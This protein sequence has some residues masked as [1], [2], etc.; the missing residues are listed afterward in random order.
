M[1]DTNSLNL[2]NQDTDGARPRDASHMPA[3]DASGHTLFE[4]IGVGGMGEVYRYG[5]DALQRDLAIKVI[6]PEM[7]GDHDAEERFLREA[8]LTGAL[9]HPGIVPVHNLGRLADGR[10]FYTM[11]LVRGRTLA[12]LLRD[13]SDGPERLPRLLAVVEK[14]CQAVAY[15]HS[16]GVIHRDLKPSCEPTALR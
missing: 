15:A 4:R 10:L 7:H 1:P 6:K 5:D 14:V 9:Q 8:R 11:K 13:E 3:P 16:R 2:P 12:D